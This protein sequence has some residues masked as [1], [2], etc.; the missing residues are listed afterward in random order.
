MPGFFRR[1]QVFLGLKSASHQV[2]KVMRAVEKKPEK[3]LSTQGMISRKWQSLFRKRPT[4]N[5][6]I[7]V[8]DALRIFKAG[9][10]DPAKVELSNYQRQV[11]NA[12][13]LYSQPRNRA[14][15]PAQTQS[16]KPVLGR[17]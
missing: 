17:V 8:E 3:Q 16:R 13:T 2:P 4:L 10:F 1:V 14:N 5:D 9:K 7:A 6:V 15:K 12:M 11:F